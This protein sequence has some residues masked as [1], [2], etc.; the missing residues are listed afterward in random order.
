MAAYRRVDDRLRAE[1]LHTGIS[2]GRNARVWEAF[3]YLVIYL[4]RPY[5]YRRVMG[6][7]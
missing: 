6:P 2:S 5:Q 7:A 1:S 3:I 4:V